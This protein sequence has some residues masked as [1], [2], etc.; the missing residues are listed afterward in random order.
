MLDN[1]LGQLLV[2]PRQSHAQEQRLAVRPADHA[3]PVHKV[4]QHGEHA[5]AGRLSVL[6]QPEE[7]VQQQRLAVQRG[8]QLRQH[9]HQPPVELHGLLGGAAAGQQRRQ[10]T[11]HGPLHQQR[12]RRLTQQLLI[13]AQLFQ[14]QLLLERA[15]ARAPVQQPLQ[16]ALAEEQVEDSQPARRCR[17]GAVG[18]GGGGVGGVLGVLE[19]PQQQGA[20]LVHVVQHAVDVVGR[21][22]VGTLSVAV[23]N[24]SAWTVQQQ[25]VTDS[26]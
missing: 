17:V 9:Q 13:D 7:E 15:A 18:G 16:D 21:G 14:Q 24:L 25:H 26:E 19:V 2:L 1:I 23:D 20:H 11:Q 10:R 3:V 4:H 6:V 5:E 8:A 12:R 22:G